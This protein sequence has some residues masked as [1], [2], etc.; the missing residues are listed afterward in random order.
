V[1]IISLIL[2][3]YTLVWVALY[4]LWESGQILHLNRGDLRILLRENV[5]GPKK[6]STELRINQAQYLLAVFCVMLL[7]GLVQAFAPLLP[8]EHYAQPSVMVTRLGLIVLGGI[9][10]AKQRSVRKQRERLDGYY[11]QQQRALEAAQIHMHRRATDP[12]LEGK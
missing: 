3:K 10:I 1:T 11:D 7:I 6:L 12:P 4:G 5:N 8:L 2:F 9:L